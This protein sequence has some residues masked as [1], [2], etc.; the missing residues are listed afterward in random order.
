LLSSPLRRAEKNGLT[1][2]RTRPK[3]WAHT[4]HAH[5]RRHPKRARGGKHPQERR[6]N[7]KTLRLTFLQQLLPL[8]N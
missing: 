4:C 2:R 6:I 1:L 3:H 7:I 5:Q 8:D